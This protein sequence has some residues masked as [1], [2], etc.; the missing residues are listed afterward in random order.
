M[1]IQVVMEELKEKP[2]PQLKHERYPNYHAKGQS[3][4][5]AA[6]GSVGSESR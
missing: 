5:K 6:A 2:L 1:A 3:D 4:Q